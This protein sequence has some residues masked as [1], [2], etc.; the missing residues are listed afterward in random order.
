MIEILITGG[1]LISCVVIS[2]WVLPR[3]G[4]PE[5]EGAFDWIRL[6]LFLVP[7]LLIGWRVLCKA[8]RNIAHG[9]VFDENFLMTVATIGAL[10]VGEYPEAVFVMLFYRVGE[11]F[12]EIAVGKSR[13][14]IADL[15][16]IRPDAANVERGGEVVGVFPD[17]VAVGEIIVIRPG[18]RI[19]L[20]GEVIEGATELDTA[21]LTG[22]SMP[23]DVRVGDAVI[24]GCVNLTG[25]IRVRVTKVFGEST[26][27]RILEL[28][29]NAGENK[30]RSEHFVRPVCHL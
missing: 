29:E 16:S 9:Q 22:E 7:Y 30:S 4:R 28:V 5:T 6:C 24:S 14:S 20:D 2:A 25:L 12:E 17:E 26:V 23:R 19:P 13:A 8:G 11:L 1:L 27:S 18:E 15:M 21:A 10:V 3:L